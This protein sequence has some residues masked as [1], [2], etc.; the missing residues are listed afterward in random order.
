MEIIDRFREPSTYAALGG[1][2]AMLAVNLDDGIVAQI[3][4]AGACLSFFLGTLL[5][6]KG[7]Y[8]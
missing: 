2:L 7:R 5:K 3:A 1:F 6:E 4:Q 8:Y